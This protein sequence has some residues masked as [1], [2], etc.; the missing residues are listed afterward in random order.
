MRFLAKLDGSEEYSQNFKDRLSP[1]LLWPSDP[2]EAARHE[3]IQG[4]IEKF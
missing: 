4:K 3:M 1:V 2:L